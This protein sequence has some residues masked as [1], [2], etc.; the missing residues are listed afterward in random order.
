MVGK[1]NTIWATLFAN[2]VTGS[3]DDG[4]SD[5]KHTYWGEVL[6]TSHKISFVR[7]NLEI[8]QVLIFLSTT[9][10]A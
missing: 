7:C 3:W 6:S 10:V 5:T 9:G 8:S 1:V 4:E 2:V